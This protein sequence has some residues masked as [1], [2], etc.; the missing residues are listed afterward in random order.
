MLIQKKDLFLPF[1]FYS[2]PRFIQWALKDFK[3]LTTD[4]KSSLWAIKCLCSLTVISLYFGIGLLFSVIFSDFCFNYSS[5]VWFVLFFERR[6]NMPFAL[7]MD[8]LAPEAGVDTSFF[9]ISGFWLVNDASKFVEFILILC[10]IKSRHRVSR[11]GQCKAFFILFGI[12]SWVNDENMFLK[13][14]CTFL[15]ILLSLSSF[16]EW[17]HTNEG[18]MNVC[19]NCSL[20]WV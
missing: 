11:L 15:L 1:S 12:V 10:H 18:D 9:S 16:F 19:S 3:Q 6:L 2:I 7:F 5:K 20:L 8:K 4:K 17:K 14:L 13:F